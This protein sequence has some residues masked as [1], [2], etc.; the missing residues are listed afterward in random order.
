ME[1]FLDDIACPAAISFDHPVSQFTVQGI[2]YFHQ[3]TQFSTG[4][5]GL[6]KRAVTVVCSAFELLFDRCVQVNHGAT[7]G[8]VLPV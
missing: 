2:A 5:A 4:V 8:Q 7:G 3:F 1:Y 6:Q